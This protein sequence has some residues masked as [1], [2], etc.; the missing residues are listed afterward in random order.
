MPTPNAKTRFIKVYKQL[1]KGGKSGKTNLFIFNKKR[2]VYII[3]ER[4]NKTGQEKIVYI[5]SSYEKEINGKKSKADL[6]KT[7]IRHFQDWEEHPER[8]TGGLSFKKYLNSRTYYVRVIL[9]NTVK[10]AENLEKNLIQKY[11]KRGAAKLKNQVTYKEYEPTQKELDDLEFFENLPA[12][13]LEKIY[14][15][16]YPNATADDIPF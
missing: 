15:E 7:I 16:M 3:K 4:I 14:L 12:Q 8:N 10:R 5:G 2:G 6:Y 1:P 13:S 9:C 11:G